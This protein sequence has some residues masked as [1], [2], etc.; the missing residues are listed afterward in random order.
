MGT[1]TSDGDSETA[2]KMCEP[3]ATEHSALSRLG[4]CI[5]RTRS[6]R[7]AGRRCSSASEPTPEFRRNPRT[8][9][10]EL[11]VNPLKESYSPRFRPRS[12]SLTPATR[13][14]IR[15]GHSAELKVGNGSRRAPARGGQKK[16]EAIASPH[17]QKRRGDYCFSVSLSKG[18]YSAKIKKS[19]CFTKS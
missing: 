10:L 11:H 19:Y 9:R 4:K 12:R 6:R 15:A 16:G 1:Q 2:C 18:K 17:H 14:G 13:A 8:R 5:L 7:P 3:A